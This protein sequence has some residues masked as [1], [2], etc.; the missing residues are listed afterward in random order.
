MTN[1]FGARATL[2]AGGREHE[3]YRLDALQATYDVARLPYTL[4]V[5]LENVLRLEDGVTV[6]GDDV[7]AVAR[8]V[9]DEEPSREISFTPARVLLQDFTGVPTIVDLGAM[10]DAMRAAGGDPARINPLL[11]VELVIDHSVQVDVFG[12][13]F[14]F[15]RNGELEF[16]RNRE[17]YA[18][19]RW[20]QEAF[21]DLKV[22]PPETGIVHQVN[23]EYLARVIEA[24]EVGGRLQAFPDTLV[25]TDSHTTMVNGLGVLGWG[26]GGI[27]A[28]AAMLGE[29]ISM[30]VPQV[31]GFKLTGRL[32]EGTTGT[33]LVLTVT[34]LLRQVGVVGKFVEF[35]GHGLDGLPLADRATIANMAP[36]CGSTCNFFPIDA[37]TLR[38]LELTARPADRIALVEAYARDQGLFHD[39]DEEPTYSQV[40]ELDLGDVEPSLAGPRRPQDRVPLAEAKAAFEAALAGFGVELTNT[41]D[42]AVEGSFPASDPPADIVPGHKP[43]QAIA[44][45]ATAAAEPRTVPVSLDGNR[46]D[47][48]HGDVVIAAI[49]SCTNTSNPAVMVGAGLLA[50]RAVE[51]GLSR[52]PWVKSSLAPGSK[53]VTEYLERAGLTHYLDELGFNL[54]GYGC[55]TC[56]GNSG[57]LPEPIS[58]AVSD[59]DLIVCAVLS[60]NRNFEA[61]IHSEVKANYLA[62]PPLVVAYALAGRM[63]VD[64][65]SEPLGQ[66]ADGTDVYLSDLWPSPAEIQQVIEHSLE[67]DMF[68][69]TYADVFAGDERWNALPIPEGDL[70]TWEPASTYVRLPPYF[71]GMPPEPPGLADIEGARCL[72]M[73]GDSVT[74]DHI[75]PAG[76]IKPDSPA[77]R[78]LLDQDVEP[79][80]FNSYGSRRGNHEVMVR[81]T[82][83]NVRLRNQLVPDGEGSVTLHLPDGERTSIYEASLRYRDEGVPL[84]VLA[85]KEYGSG[86]SRDWA[87]KGPALLGV[88]A[89]IAESFERIHRSNLLMMGI[90]PLQL[91]AGDTLGS[92]GLSGLETFSVTGLENGE[93]R[94]VPVTATPDG[95]NPIRFTCRVRLDTPRERDYAR[96]GGILPFVLRRLT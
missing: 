61:R 66:G 86:S 48:S 11:P 27:E 78:Y 75:S 85:G 83:A 28:E 52:R 51:R 5:L 15:E 45:V 14:A 59:G 2:S 20:G 38:Y 71:D 91:A 34:E 72:V 69:R 90:V 49:T 39:P 58:Q 12:T 18:F 44:P 76:S 82:F 60:G 8:W 9:A 30:L 87:A 32:S 33:D 84:V 96:H 89:V 65:T 4:R 35:F 67:R 13:R 81:G 41:H 70:Y 21:A 95:G 40:V 62:S 50:K 56:I 22:V 77:G 46:F 29:P 26:V 43:E 24:R 1:S 17:R 92:L 64:L 57:P 42:E 36:E 6:T 93:A 31:V 16:A 88:R 19:L 68:E 55:T 47:L 74:T 79:A 73:V 37:E 3:I 7:E 25:G 63:D 54:V 53:V 23:L 94:E 80:D 10:R